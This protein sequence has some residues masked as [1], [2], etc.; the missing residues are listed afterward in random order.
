[1][2]TSGTICMYCKKMPADGEDRCC[3]TCRGEN[4]CQ[5]LTERLTK[6]LENFFDD[7]WA[8]HR[9]GQRPGT[10]SPAGLRRP[11]IHRVDSDWIEFMWSDDPR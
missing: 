9:Y 6:V 7:R 10:T 8:P 5:D 1:M 4:A 11:H 3:A 2:T